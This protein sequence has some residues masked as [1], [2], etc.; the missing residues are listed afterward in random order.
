MRSEVTKLVHLGPGE[1]DKILTVIL[2]I[3]ETALA[4]KGETSSII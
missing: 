3:I 4:T 1:R 2:N